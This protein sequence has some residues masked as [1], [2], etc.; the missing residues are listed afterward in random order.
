[1]KKYEKIFGLAL[2]VIFLLGLLA[3]CATPTATEAAPVTTEAAPAATT[4]PTAVPPT[5][6]PPT[7]AVVS[8]VGGNLIYLSTEEPDTLDIQTSVMSIACGMVGFIGDP[9]IAKDVNG[10]YIPQIAESW[11][12][13]TDGLT[14]TFKIRT[15]V[16][17]HNGDPMTA[18]DWEYTFNRALDP[19]F[20]APGAAPS[21]ASVASVVAPDDTTLVITL[22]AANYYFLDTLAGNCYLT[23][24]DQK[25]VEAG[26]NKYGLSEIGIVGTGPYIF[27]EWVQDETITLERNPD[28]NWGAVLFDGAQTGPWNIETVTLRVVPDIATITA[29]MLAGEVSYSGVQPQ[30]L[31]AI[32]DSGLYNIESGPVPAYLYLLINSSLAPTNDVHFRRA[33]AFA[34]NRDEV[35]QVVA[36]GKG[37]K[38]LGSLSPVMIGYDPVQETYGLEY[39]P[40]QAKAE[41]LLAGFTYG[42]D[43]NLIG[44]DGQPFEIDFYTTADETGT[45]SAQV[46][47][48]QFAAVG[49]VANIQ[50]LEWGTL[51]AKLTAGE[52]NI[53]F[54]G[55]GW[56]NADLM[57]MTYHSPGAALWTFVNDPQMD[58][59]L[60]SIRTTTDPTAQ[61]AAVNAVVK[62][63]IENAY[64]VPWYSPQTFYAVDKNISEYL[65]SPVLAGVLFQNAYFTNL[66]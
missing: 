10:Q 18:H 21:L 66:P 56:P 1:M 58:T 63:I 47:Q 39:D 14:W 2:A 48:A 26:G 45:K 34:T 44:P 13:S 6:V 57:Y 23:V 41:F 28:Y 62:Y 20:A 15:D 50:Q 38:I 25:A 27:K 29:A 51:A 42:S 8:K 32:T 7:E 22:K 16:K 49:L 4:P 5:A 33:M 36:Q 43:G 60:E 46:V 9:L 64:M 24:Y 37:V 65:Y 19:N 12:A 11:T 61:Q 55:V 59:L 30:D 53:S 54:M 40:D 52:Y 3:G 17:F 31:Q 35:L